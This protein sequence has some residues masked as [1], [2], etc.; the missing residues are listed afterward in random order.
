MPAKA[1]SFIKN[2]SCVETRAKTPK[3][4]VERALQSSTWN[5]SFFLKL[6]FACSLT[7]VCKKKKKSFSSLLL[8]SDFDIHLSVQHSIYCFLLIK[9]KTM[10]KGKHEV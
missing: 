10:T 7:V 4:R 6:H 8:Y 5:T 9:A 1:T 2:N 3:I